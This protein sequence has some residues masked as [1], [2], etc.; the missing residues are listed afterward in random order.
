MYFEKL[1][2]DINKPASRSSQFVVGH[3][4]HPAILYRCSWNGCFQGS[5]NEQYKMK[6]EGLK[7][8]NR[9]RSMLNELRE[10]IS[11]SLET[12]ELVTYE[13]CHSTQ[14]S[15]Q[16]LSTCSG[17]LQTIESLPGILYVVYCCYF[18]A[19]IVKQ[20]VYFGA[21]RRKGRVKRRRKY[22]YYGVEPSYF[23]VF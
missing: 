6:A 7:Q 11:E 15:R 9:H 8:P 1:D 4:A 14:M 17:R 20:I 18:V 2:L 16:G 3:R 19:Y 5:D 10:M 22:A 21:D 13:G 23:M 12:P